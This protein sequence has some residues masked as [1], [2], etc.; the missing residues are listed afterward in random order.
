ME[1]GNLHNFWEKS[2][3]TDWFTRH[4]VLAGESDLSK[5]VPLGMHGDDAGVYNNEKFTWVCVER[6]V[7]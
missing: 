6:S 7:R 5:V 1:A 3:N 2:K 4:P